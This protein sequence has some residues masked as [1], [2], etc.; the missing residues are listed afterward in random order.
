MCLGF[1]LLGL[2]NTFP[3]ESVRTSG[4]NMPIENQWSHQ[5]DDANCFEE[6]FVVH[7]KQLDTNLEIFLGFLSSLYNTKIFNNC[8]QWSCH[9]VRSL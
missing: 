7:L 3:G 9:Y 6:F 1:I 4:V 2:I 5:V 8:P